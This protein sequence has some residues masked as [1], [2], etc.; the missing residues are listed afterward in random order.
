MVDPGRRIAALLGTVLLLAGGTACSGHVD[1]SVGGPAGISGPSLAD[2]LADLVSELSE[3]TPESMDCPDG[4]DAEIGAT[5]TCE[6]V[7]DDVRS[8]VA[9]EATGLREDEETLEFVWKV[10]PG[11]QRLLTDRVGDIIADDFAEATGLTLTE[12]T[13][14]EPELAGTSTVEMSCDAVT[15]EG[16]SGP[17]VLSAKGA[18]GLQV[19]FSWRLGDQTRPS[20]SSASCGEAAGGQRCG[21]RND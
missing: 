13:C 8:T 11:S 20:G 10:E 3:V 19:D 4:L 17:V 16:R 9:V 18:E 2:D 21:D 5:T 14:P 7:H 12:L 15:A 1:V 6:M